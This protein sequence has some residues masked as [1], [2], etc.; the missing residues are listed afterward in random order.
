MYQECTPRIMYHTYLFL[1]RL[2]R[3]LT[4]G[5]VDTEG[6]VSH[7]HLVEE[8]SKQTHLK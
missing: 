1:G 6:K 5:T 8:L 3:A 4:E 7:E 2:L